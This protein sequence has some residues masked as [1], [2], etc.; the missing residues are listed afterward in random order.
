MNSADG[1]TLLDNLE[2]GLP[3]GTR[4]KTLFSLDDA[5]GD[6]TV[7]EGGRLSVRLP[8]CSGVVWQAAAA[9]APAP[10]G[11]AQIDIDPLPATRF[12]EDFTVSGRARGV[13][14]LD[15]V[16][17]GDLSR[18]LR[19]LPGAD[20]C[21]QAVVDTSRMVDPVV[22]HHVTAWVEGAQQAA[23]A[24]QFFVQRDWTLQADIADPAGD[25]RGR[26]SQLTY[27]TDPSFAARQMDL[28]RV[29]VSTSGGAL[30]LD[31]TM[32]DI[33][34]VWS[35]PQGFDHVAFTV[36]IELPGQ[37]GGAT[38]MPQQNGDVPASMRWHRRLRV[39]GWSNA[40]FSSEGASA[41][42]DGV[43]VAP[44]ALI[45]TD[46]PSRTVS[47]VLP[48]AALGGLEVAPGG[49][50]LRHHLGLR[51]RLPRASASSPAFRH[52]RGRRHHTQG[53]GRKRG[54]RAALNPGPRRRGCGRR[55]RNSSTRQPW[56]S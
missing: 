35:P 24:Q 49:Q 42:N 55:A 8:G 13:A 30:R 53:H 22:R 3:S 12:S 27:P 48:A 1:D 18:A 21:W 40:L 50:G 16:V 43:P 39:A 23:L 33:S 34:T 31:L 36:F 52:G 20:G 54:D 10:P 47:L 26:S 41:T 11:S 9:T 44:A 17:D 46:A 5:V 6:A 7:G 2:T 51:R 25:D 19:V 29:Q 56:L 4:L 14:A 37:P 28:R 38:V 32:A 45:S 15:L